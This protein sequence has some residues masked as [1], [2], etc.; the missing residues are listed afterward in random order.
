MSC[1][2]FSGGTLATASD[3]RILSMM[4]LSLSEPDRATTVYRSPSGWLNFMATEVAACLPNRRFCSVYWRD[5]EYSFSSR[6]RRFVS[7]SSRARISSPVSSTGSV[8][9]APGS[10]PSPINNTS[11]LERRDV[12]WSF[13]PLAPR[14]AS[15]RNRRVSGFGTRC[16][17]LPV[18]GF[19]LMEF[20]LQ[21]G[22]ITRVGLGRDRQ[23]EVLVEGEDVGSEI[24]RHFGIVAI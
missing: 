2:P 6:W 19:Q 10:M 14:R 5:I 9:A 8:V 4:P 7:F 11:R 23:A 16:C 15:F 1:C 13:R 24:L 20:F 17:Q 21:P 3:A 22:P 12:L 18:D